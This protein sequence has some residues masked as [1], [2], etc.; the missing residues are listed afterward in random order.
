MPPAGDHKSTSLAAHLRQML[1]SGRGHTMGALAVRV[2]AAG[3]A[4]VLQIVLARIL[5]PADYGVFN[6]T[7]NILTIGGFLATL[8]FSELAVRFLAQYHARNEFALASG[9]LQTGLRVTLAGAIVAGL[10]GL[11]LTPLMVHAYGP[12]SADL[13]RYGLLALPFF[14][15]S[16]YL[17]GVARSQGWTIRALA[18]HYVLRQTL[19]ILMIVALQ[20]MNPPVTPVAAMLVMVVASLLAAVAHVAL[21]SGHVEQILPSTPPTYDLPTWWAAATPTLLSN[22]ALLARLNIDLIVLGLFVPASTVG[23]YFAATRLASLLGLLEFA[24]KAGMGH[25][26]ARAAQ[27]ENPDALRRVYGEAQRL[28]LWPGLA[29]SVVLALASPFVL[30]IFGPDFV[31]ATSLTLVLIVATAIRLVIGPADEALAMSGHPRLVWRANGVGALV[32]GVGTAALAPGLGAMGA[33]VATL[34]GSLVS[35]VMMMLYLRRHLG[36]VPFLR[37]KASSPEEG[38]QEQ[39]P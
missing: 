24:I 19:I 26:F 33:A 35:T 36:I 27:D 31:A 14:A 25:R 22:L 18:P 15:L 11:L 1:A 34:L 29:A 4:Y 9:F 21:L 13:L 17:G 30:R 32:M 38:S 12:L 20:I 8:G 7:W 37:S 28:S 5:G 16:D 6:I 10:C 39:K 23:L 2:A 3:L